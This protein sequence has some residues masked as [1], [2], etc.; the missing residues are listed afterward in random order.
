MLRLRTVPLCP[1]DLVHPGGQPVSSAMQATCEV[2]H[3]GANF[4]ANL[5]RQVLLVEEGRWER[6]PCY[7]QV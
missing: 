6:R 7:N 1:H 3:V 4:C 5:H 2:L